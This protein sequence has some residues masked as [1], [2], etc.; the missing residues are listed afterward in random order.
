MNNKNGF[1]T[2]MKISGNFLIS[3]T[4][5]GHVPVLDLATF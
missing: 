2:D 3:S 4:I 1:I 5:K